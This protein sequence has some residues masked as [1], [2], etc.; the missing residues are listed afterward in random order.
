MDSR[1]D[2]KKRINHL[3]VTVQYVRSRNLYAPTVKQ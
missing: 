2:A 1:S 3:R